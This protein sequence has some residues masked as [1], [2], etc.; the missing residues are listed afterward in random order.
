MPQLR[1]TCTQM[2][3]QYIHLEF[4]ESFMANGIRLL[5]KS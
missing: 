5:L 1:F 4:C 2:K 3:E